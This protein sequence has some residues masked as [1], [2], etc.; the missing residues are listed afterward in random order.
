MVPLELFPTIPPIVHLFDVEVLGPKNKL[1]GVK[2]L[3]KSSLIIPG[4]TTTVC[5]SSL[6]SITEF[7]Y[8][9]ISTT[10]PSPTHCPANDVPAA[11]GINPTP[12]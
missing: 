2:N 6:N 11:R 1:K 8:L 10:K 3:F 12:S 5:S 7:K 4:S 9:E